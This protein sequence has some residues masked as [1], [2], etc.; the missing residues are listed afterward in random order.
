L[1]LRGA[2]LNAVK[3][4]FMKK[5]L[6]A[7]ILI[8][9]LTACGGNPGGGAAFVKTGGSTSVE[10]VVL[11]LI[12]RFQ[13]E[14]N[15]SVDYEPKGSGDGVINTLSGLYEIGHSSRELKTDGSEDGLDAIAYAIDGIAVVVNR[16]NPVGNLTREQLFG[17]YTGKI[18]NWNE[19]GGADAL[20]TLI[21]RESGSGTKTAFADI[22]GL[23]RR[24]A[25]GG[26]DETTKIDRYAAVAGD[27][28]AIQS[29]VEQN[30]NAIG[31]LSFSDIDEKKVKAISYENVKISEAS[32]RD[33]SYALKRR[34][35]LLT[36]T[37]AELSAEARA[38]LNFVLS[39]EGR[40]IIADNKLLPVR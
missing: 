9:L 35:L 22:I 37:G 17:I 5:F 31:Y 8:C 27:T 32:L 26:F 29:A 36:K 34:F 28:G 20:I 2:G 4:D 39:D 25:D 3:K 18:K 12:F 24:G 14:N 13:A 6:A 10:K 38:F 19:V 16:N 1:I 11:A 33:G 15:I 7:L 30:S 23:D 21:T 40:A